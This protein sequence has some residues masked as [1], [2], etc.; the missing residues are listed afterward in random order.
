M[1]DSVLKLN[2]QT[3]YYVFDRSVIKQSYQKFRDLLP[4]VE[5]HYAVKSNPLE[6]VAEVLN[7]LG[8]HFEIASPNELKMLVK[9][10]VPVDHIICS[11]PVK[12]GAFIKEAH[13]LGITKFAFDS[14][15]ELE[16]ITQSAP[17]SQVY[18]RLK[19]T[20][21]G[22]RFS[23]SEKFGVSVEKA[24]EYMAYAKELNL[25]PY[26]LTF[27]I[28]SQASSVYS[29]RYAIRTAAKAMCLLQ[30]AGIKIN[31]LDIG[32]GFP[33]SYVDHE[34]SLDDVANSVKIALDKYL[35]YKVRILAEP[36]RAL[37]AESA[38][39]VTSVFGR[40]KRGRENWLFTDAGAYNSLFEALDSQ[41]A[42]EYEVLPAQKRTNKV[43]SF[44]ITGP[45]CDSLDIL[46]RSASLP[47]DT[48]VGDKLVFLKAG[49]YTVALANS[50][51]GYS[52]PDI[53]FIN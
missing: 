27:H 36:G 18:L 20:E 30:E 9:I 26:G 49:A 33:M 31:M 29:W 38:V 37:I 51:N 21:H 25:K 6:E 42:L 8:S 35:P 5:V 46:R 17:G 7:Q 23:L 34:P 14:R 2:Y 48:H 1:N 32:G 45:T 15:E 50:F 28:G 13:D 3:P 40:V 22:S 16:K 19:V 47:A 53:Y 39:L 43:S 52:Q 24:V 11:A 41:T 12:S 4:D 44:V 10:G